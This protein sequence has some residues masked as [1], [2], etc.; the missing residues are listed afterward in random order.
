VP[1]RPPKNWMRECVAAVGQ[2]GGAKDAGAVCASV[3]QGKSASERRAIV[4]LEEGTRMSA[5]KKKKPKKKAPKRSKAKKP[6]KKGK[7]HHRCTGC[8]HLHAGPCLHMKGSAICPCPR[9]KH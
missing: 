1:G 6:R 2:H 9:P 8:G 5:K 4:E 7:K 3:W